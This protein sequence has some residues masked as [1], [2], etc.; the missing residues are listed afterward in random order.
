MPLIV[1]RRVRAE[2][3]NTDPPDCLV[4]EGVCLPS[5]SLLPSHMDRAPSISARHFYAVL[6]HTT[7]CQVATL[8][9]IRPL[10]SSSAGVAHL[11]SLVLGLEQLCSIYT[12]AL[13]ILNVANSCRCSSPPV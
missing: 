10:F 13:C 2:K 11:D 9:A 7:G 4:R 6:L 8:R 5:G 3:Y 12:S 1:S